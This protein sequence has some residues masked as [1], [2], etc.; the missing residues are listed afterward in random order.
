MS[1]KLRI[2][3]E[4]EKVYGQ[5]LQKTSYFC[6]NYAPSSG[7]QLASPDIPVAVYRAQYFAPLQ[8]IAIV[9]L[10]QS[11]VD[12]RYERGKLLGVVEAGEFDDATFG[13]DEDIARDACLAVGIEGE[14][15]STWV[16]A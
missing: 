11:F 16:E 12:E 4:T 13:V 10:P 6:N 3:F 2:N 14:D 15:I 5:N 9:L 1:A 8:V 7:L